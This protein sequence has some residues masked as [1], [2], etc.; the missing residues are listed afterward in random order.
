MDGHRVL[1]RDK[2]MAPTKVATQD[3]CPLGLSE[4]WEFQTIRGPN[5]DPK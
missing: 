2:I 4:I 5:I 1:Y 3:S